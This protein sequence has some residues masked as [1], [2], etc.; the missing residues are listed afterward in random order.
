KALGPLAGLPV[1][2]KKPRSPE[3]IAE[4]KKYFGDWCAALE[5]LDFDNLSRPGQVDYVLLRHHLERELRRLEQE[6]KAEP[7]GDKADAKGALPGR[8]VGREVLA[9]ELRAEMI[10]YTPEELLA[11]AEKEFAWCE[12]EM[13]KASRDL[14]LGD[15]WHKA[16][17]KAKTLHVEPGRQPQLIADL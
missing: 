3:R 10:P 1:A 6:G 15:D 5:Q 2:G 12:A 7:A 11:V 13:K 4:L 8:A 16:V 17:E 9:S 14:D